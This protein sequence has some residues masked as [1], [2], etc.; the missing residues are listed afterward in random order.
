MLVR[1]MGCQLSSV[2]TPLCYEIHVAHAV[3]ATPAN[4]SE[5]V[6]K[7]HAHVFK[8]SL[9][10]ATL[11]KRLDGLAKAAAVKKAKAPTKQKAGPAPNHASR[12]IV[13]NLPF[14]I[15]E[16]DLRAIFL[17]YGP[18]YSVH[19]PLASDVKHED[20]VK[21]ENGD[22]EPARPR[23]KGFA[24]VW[25]L[26]RK[27]AE[28]AMQA[29]NGMTVEA[30]MAE[31]LVSDKQKKKKQRREEKKRKAKEGEDAE[32]EDEEQEDA[33]RRTIAVDWALSKD[34]WE[35]EKAK[36]EAQAEEDADVE[37]SD[38]EDEA[39]VSSK[40]GDS[41][42]DEGGDSDSKD[43]QLGV[44]EDDSEDGRSDADSSDSHP[45][46]EDEEGDEEQQS[47]VKPTLPPPEVGTTVFVRNVPFEA[48]ED[49]LRT[50]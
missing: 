28:K 33:G 42:D 13:R 38:A 19:I 39:S 40:D 5:A 46:D 3:F 17:P 27:D 49:E 36:L 23:S 16:Q 7:L 47:P 8:G 11:K 48:T 44:H 35:A 25:F 34:K 15:T 32:Q 10:S 37:M 50:L 21:S 14:D 29:C 22:S 31:A 30:G 1:T 24:F 2:N 18:I 41:E 6:N 26:S 9:L 20:D 12:L 43:E 45:D 4:A